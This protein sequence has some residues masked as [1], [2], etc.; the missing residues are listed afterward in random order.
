M[1]MCHFGKNEHRT[2]NVQHRMLNGKDEE[3]EH[4]FRGSGFRVQMFKCSDV[5]GFKKDEETEIAVECSV[6]DIRFLFDVRRSM[7]DVH[8]LKQ[9]RT[10]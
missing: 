1:V 9:F 4:G 5:Q 10:A 6:S 2:S 7:F 3:T 8:L